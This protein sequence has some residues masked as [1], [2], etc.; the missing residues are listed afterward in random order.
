MAWSKTILI[1]LLFLI[2]SCASN[3]NISLKFYSDSVQ[4]Q[5][6]L[7]T[8]SVD[9]IKPYEIL[10]FDESHKEVYTDTT[11]SEFIKSIEQSDS[12]IESAADSISVFENIELE[13]ANVILTTISVD[14]SVSETEIISITNHND[15][16]LVNSER[17]SLIAPIDI[18]NE[19]DTTLANLHIVTIDSIQVLITDSTK[20]TEFDSHD[21]TSNYVTNN[22]VQPDQGREFYDT[23][24]TT[25]DSTQVKIPIDTT[26]FAVSEEFI[27]DSIYQDSTIILNSKILHDSIYS[28]ITYNEIHNHYYNGN[29][30]TKLQ[31]QFKDLQDQFNSLN[32]EF[33]HLKKLISNGSK[34]DS[35][36]N[37]IKPK[38]EDQVYTA[39]FFFK[40]GSISPIISNQT[41]DSLQIIPVQYKN[42]LVKIS[43]Y[44]DNSGSEKQNLELSRK[45]AEKMKQILVQYG[46]NPK[47]IFIQYFGEQYAQST[48]AEERKVICEI[49]FSK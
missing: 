35:A 15:T 40:I 6:S 47:F 25:Y 5:D 20:T 39:Q 8:A 9:S 1:S 41:K 21:T 45:R 13:D 16:I 37:E 38:N 32:S 18:I 28:E 30:D 7:A 17:D 24:I 29:S 12:S 33:S 3:R 22:L 23:L 14:S 31:E 19:F 34:L 43:S 46:Y 49:S 4:K 10:S 36:Q 26:I 27:L 44:T 48:E 42:L 2:V 11:F